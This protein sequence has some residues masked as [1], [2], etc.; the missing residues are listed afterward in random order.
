MTL[1]YSIS[2]VWLYNEIEEI[3]EKYYEKV[4]FVLN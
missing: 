1:N 2:F 4:G 3:N